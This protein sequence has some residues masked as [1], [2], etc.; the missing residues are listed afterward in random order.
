MT[1]QT[2]TLSTSWQGLLQQIMQ[3]SAQHARWLNTLSLL[4]HIG[5]RKIIKALDSNQLTLPLLSHISEETRH[6]LMFKQFAER[7]APGLCPTYDAQHLLCGRQARDYIADLD[8]DT[9]A[10]LAGQGHSD[11]LLCYL[12]VTL[13]VEERATEIYALYDHLLSR[14]N[15][16]IRLRAIL[17]EEEKHLDDMHAHFDMLRF[18]WRDHAEALRAIE[19]R[20]FAQWT[21]ALSAELKAS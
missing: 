4:E 19:T 3:D 9:A 18:S 16:P 7:V 20:H 8:N 10:H 2:Q 15:A 14:S 11:P 1:A 21:D 6:A 5:S 12:C 13:L 17:N